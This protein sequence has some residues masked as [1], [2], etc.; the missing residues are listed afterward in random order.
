MKTYHLE[1]SMSARVNFDQDVSRWILARIDKRKNKTLTTDELN[2]WM[3]YFIAN[4]E[5]DDEEEGEA[6]FVDTVLKEWNEAFNTN[7][8]VVKVLSGP[9]GNVYKIN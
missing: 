3:N 4:N 7:Y 2:D 1:S 8:H 6:R 9:F 5:I